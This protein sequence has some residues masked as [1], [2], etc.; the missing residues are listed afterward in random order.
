MKRLFV[1]ALLCILVAA[2]NVVQG[3]NNMQVK[4]QTEVVDSNK[5]TIYLAGG[6]FWGVEG[7]F[8][9]VAGIVDT[10]T[11]YANGKTETANYQQL[12]ETD[13]AETVK[14]VYDF[15]K[16]S[17]EEVLLHYF[18]I[19]DPTSINKQGNDV[20]R[21]YRTGIYYENKVDLPVIN[22][23][24]A[25]Q[26]EKH[27]KLA[28]EVQA[29]NHF[30]LAEEYHQDYLEKN[31]TGY[32]HINLQTATQPLIENELQF[33]Q[34][35]DKSEIDE[36]SQNVMFANG[37]ESPFTSELNSEYRKGI[38]V[39]KLTGEPLFASKDKFDSGCGWPSFSKPI[40]NDKIN[41]NIDESHGMIRTEV[42]AKNSDIHLGHVFPD[43]PKDKGGIRYCI[44]GASLEF[45]PYEE[46]DAKGYSEYKILCE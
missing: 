30:V 42:R 14:I 25:Y 37:T 19:I 13:H 18:R 26:T 44:N 9:K 22:K 32:C 15:S 31:P 27:G 16:I 4:I 40:L 8:Q 28:V 39:D 46:M 12:K 34:K 7:Y 38:Y 36:V 3:E 33:F 10:D 11:G 45:V 20:G 35:K 43:G 24:I 5:R 29:L 41:E 6:C 1:L 2:F 21:Q 23:V 17:L